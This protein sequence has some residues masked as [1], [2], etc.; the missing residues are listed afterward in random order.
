VRLE[1]QEFWI[2]RGV[3]LALKAKTHGE[4]P[5]CS[6]LQRWNALNVDRKSKRP[7]I[8]WALE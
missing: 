3:A 5:S 1:D 8:W 6:Q 7:P 2:V 4:R